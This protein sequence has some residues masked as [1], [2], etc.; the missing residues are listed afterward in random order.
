MPTQHGSPIY[1]DDQPELDAGSV[2]LLR[3]A[4]ALI[5]GKTTTTE[6]GRQ[7]KGNRYRSFLKLLL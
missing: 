7:T 1:K 3:Q 5:L 2:I 4:G 6:F